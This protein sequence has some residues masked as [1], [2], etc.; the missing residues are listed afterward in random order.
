MIISIILLL[1]LRMLPIPLFAK[2]IF[3]TLGIV[4][5]AFLQ[6]RLFLESRKN[7]GIGTKGL[8]LVAMV[9]MLLGIVNLCPYVNCPEHTVRAEL[10]GTEPGTFE[11]S[12][13]YS[14]CA[15]DG[16][17]ANREEE[18]QNLLEEYD[19]DFDR[20]SYIVSLGREVES[21]RYTV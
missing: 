14:V 9:S 20:Y 17:K 7:F 11:T 21:I 10:V 16:K 18:A 19:A 4:L 5:L 6:W 3:A 8:I 2:S 1:A 15:P 12:Y 13:A